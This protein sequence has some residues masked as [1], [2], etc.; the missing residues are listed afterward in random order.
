MLWCLVKTAGLRKIRKT[1]TVL[2]S[3][4]SLP[5]GNKSNS[6]SQKSS[7]IAVLYQY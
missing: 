5:K 7:D 6:F 4:F 2:T 1:W 3:I